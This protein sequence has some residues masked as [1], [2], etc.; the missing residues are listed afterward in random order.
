MDAPHPPAR[1]AAAPAPCPACHGAGTVLMSLCCGR[2]CA[3]C[4][5]DG[6]L[7]QVECGRCRGAGHLAPPAGPRTTFQP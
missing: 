7:Q 1:A 6:M 4:P 5:G 2:G 3:T